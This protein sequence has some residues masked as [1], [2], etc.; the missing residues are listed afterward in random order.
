MPTSAG[1]KP[2]SNYAK[3]SNDRLS[4]IGACH[5]ANSPNNFIPI[6][7]ANAPLIYPT[8]STKCSNNGRNMLETSRPDLS[9]IAVRRRTYCLWQPEHQAVAI[10]VADIDCVSL[11]QIRRIVFRRPARARQA[12]FPSIAGDE[13]DI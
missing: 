11:K 3:G 4:N 6:D 7:Q 2:S 9:G 12:Q 13:D 5:T 10:R 1:R 8:I